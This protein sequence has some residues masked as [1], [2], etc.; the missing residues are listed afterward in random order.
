MN[1]AHGL[2]ME[3][4][5]EKTLEPTGYRLELEPYLEDGIFKGRV[6]INVTWLEDT[7][8]VKVHCSHEIAITDTIVRARDPTD[9]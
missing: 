2:S 4:R 5:L 6:R 9:M 8:D 3:A 1:N 7:D